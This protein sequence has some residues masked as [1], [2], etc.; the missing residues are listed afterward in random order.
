[1]A[2]YTYGCADDGLVEVTLPVGTAPPHLECPQCGQP[3]R[4]VYRPPMVSAAD[5]TRMTLIDSTNGSADRPE[6][7]TAIPQGGR[8]NRRRTPTAP[9]DPRLRK[10]PRP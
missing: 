8:M 10:L 5:R 9:P 4:R 1:V 2:N 6:V 7:V 3:A